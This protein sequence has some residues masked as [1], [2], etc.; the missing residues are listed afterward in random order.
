MAP[1]VL[2]KLI[3]KRPCGYFLLTFANLSLGCGPGWGWLEG[4][5]DK[6]NLCDY[7]FG[8]W[9]QGCLDHKPG[10]LAIHS[11]IVWALKF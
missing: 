3:D 7:F 5:G 11:V 8:G 2:I 6:V 10:D 4:R 1:S 9:G